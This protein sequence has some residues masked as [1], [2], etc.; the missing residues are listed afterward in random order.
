MLV[1]V[2]LLPDVGDSDHVE[3]EQVLVVLEAVDLLAALDQV[4]EAKAEGVAHVVEQV[5]VV[6]LKDGLARAAHLLH[7]LAQGLDLLK[8]G[9]SAHGAVDSQVAQ[10]LDDP[11]LVELVADLAVDTEA[12][13]V[14]EV[15]AE[16]LPRHHCILEA[17]DLL[18]PALLLHLHL[19]FPHVQVLHLRALPLLHQSLQLLE[20]VFS[21]LRRS[22]PSPGSW[23][24][25]CPCREG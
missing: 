17:L 15:L 6:A 21:Q 12:E 16:H 3:G 1:A 11:P 24:S 4:V 19:D 23:R 8:A 2:R 18:K 7:Q 13:A 14:D 22:L 10:P 5:L 20:A 25:R 9:H